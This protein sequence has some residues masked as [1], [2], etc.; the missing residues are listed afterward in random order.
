M[1]VCLRGH[2]KTPE[3]ARPR[4]KG[5]ILCHREQERERK[6]RF[7]A[8]NPLPPSKCE[9]LGH[10]YE[11]R[12]K[13]KGCAECHRISERKRHLANLEENRRVAREYARTHKAE[14]QARHKLW[15]DANVDH[16]RAYA[17]KQQRARKVGRTDEGKEFVEILRFD[18]CSYCGGL[19]GHIDH[20]EP[21]AK[22]GSNTW[23]NL[24]A[25]CKSCNS[26]KKTKPLLMFL[27]SVA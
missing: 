1:D 4:N 8:A 22:G 11:P 17:L 18:P 9:I 21:L 2:F 6:Q 26:K 27:L 25:T 20:V 7:R 19:G 15:R 5:C 23:E 3:N 24:T 14:A 10:E 12:P 16:V 13:S